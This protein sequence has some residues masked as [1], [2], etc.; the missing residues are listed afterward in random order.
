MA[1][2]LHSSYICSILISVLL[3][4]QPPKNKLN[5]LDYSGCTAAPLLAPQTI[6]QVCAKVEKEKMLQTSLCKDI[7]ETADMPS[8]IPCFSSARSNRLTN[9]MNFPKTQLGRDFFRRWT[10]VSRLYTQLHTFKDS[11][12]FSSLLHHYKLFSGE[13]IEQQQSHFTQ[14]TYHDATRIA[15]MFVKASTTSHHTFFYAVVFFLP[16]MMQIYESIDFINIQNRFLVHKIFTLLPQSNRRLYRNTRIKVFL[17]TIAPVIFFLYLIYIKGCQHSY[18]LKCSHRGRK[19]NPKQCVP[20]ENTLSGL[21][22][23]PLY[24]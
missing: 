2:F 19:L 22:L 12:I 18:P 15:T 4:T 13:H 7:T 9:N 20:Q 21:P 10:E 17:Y 24:F 11:Y 14:F 3:S 5:V 8:H 6:F 1:M 23:T 16:H